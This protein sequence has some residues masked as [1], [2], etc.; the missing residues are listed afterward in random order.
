[1]GQRDAYDWDDGSMPQTSRSSCT[2]KIDNTCEDR[3][4]C[5]HHG[6]Q[7]EGS[8]CR[9]E[10]PKGT[11]VITLLQLATRDCSFLYGLVSGAV[12]N[13]GGGSTQQ[14]FLAIRDKC[15]P[16]RELTVNCEKGS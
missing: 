12:A 1:V 3:V 14:A 16:F 5:C 15:A 8:D 10:H 6:N 4:V 7:P 2:S 9:D 11:I 13:L